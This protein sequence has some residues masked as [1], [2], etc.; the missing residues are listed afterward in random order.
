LR[1]DT[2]REGGGG[3]KKSFDN[4]VTVIYAFREKYNPNIKVFRNGNIQMTGVRVI[5][6]GEK[7]IGIIV[8]EL[9]RIYESGHTSVVEDADALHPCDFK[10]RMINSNFSVPYLV[11]RKDLHKLLISHEYNNNCI[12]QG[13]TYPG[14]KLYFYWNSTKKKQDGICECTKACFG[15]GTGHGD[16]ECKKVTV[17]IFES[18]NVLITGA[19]TVEQID[20][21][22]AYI[23]AVLVQ[24]V[25]MLRKVLPPLLDTAAR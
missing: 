6:D 5:E 22:Y 20:S 1:S 23:T 8:D 4:Q 9:R 13:T 7:I 10:V 14:V 24:H 19:N 17:A 16:G 25:Q 11:R 12:F 15:K 18:G 3:G 21:A 2:I